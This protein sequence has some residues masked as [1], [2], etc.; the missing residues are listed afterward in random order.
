MLYEE[1]ATSVYRYLRRTLRSRQDAEDALQETFLRAFR[2]LSSGTRPETPLAWLLTIA[3]NH[4]VSLFRHSR[5]VVGLSQVEAPAAPGPQPCSDL[6][7]LSRALGS[8]PARQRQA[9]VM[10]EWC[11]CSYEEIAATLDLSYSA[12]ASHVSRGRRTLAERL[13]APLP[14]R[15]PLEQPADHDVRVEVPPRELARRDRVL[16]AL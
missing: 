1:H 6:F 16:V 12:V 2:A 10:Y 7:G 9:L 15:Q 4:C 11:G 8:L 5:P 3:R 13:E 14:E